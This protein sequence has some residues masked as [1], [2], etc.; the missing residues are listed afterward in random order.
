MILSEFAVGKTF[1]CSERQWRC[2]DIGR[3][4]VVAI[5]IDSVEV[6][7]TVTEL[8]RTLSGANAEVEG[9]FNGPPY[10]VSETVFDEYSLPACSVELP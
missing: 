5:R 9:W 3:R 2:T 7:S 4:V 8:R 1:W 6:G 10:A